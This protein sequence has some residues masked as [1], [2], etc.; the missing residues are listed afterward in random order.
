MQSSSIIAD[1]PAGNEPAHTRGVSSDGPI[2]A[3]RGVHGNAA[4]RQPRVRRCILPYAFF[5]SALIHLGVLAIFQILPDRSG[6]NI[7]M[8]GREDVRFVACIQLGTVDAVVI[9]ASANDKNASPAVAPPSEPVKRAAPSPVAAPSQRSAESAPPAPVVSANKPVSVTT[10]P[11]DAPVIQPGNG[12]S[13]GSRSSALAAS[14]SASKNVA[15][16]GFTSA[17]ADYLQNPPPRYPDLAR[18]RGWQGVAVLR[19]Q[20]RTDG[21]PDC[22]EL[23]KT[24]GH[25]MLDRASI[26]TVRGWKFS[27][28]RTGGKAVKAWVE[29]PIRFQLVNG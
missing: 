14:E 13:N 28:A 12:T 8:E 20:V 15:A 9:D 25:R 19:V 21:S 29:I 4:D 27:P 22:V 2:A 6:P 3:A 17:R 16:G 18:R 1:L 11:A 23:L 5:G 10:A 26:E 7:G 24:S